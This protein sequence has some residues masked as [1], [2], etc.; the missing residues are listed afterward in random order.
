[1][2]LNG[3]IH[4]RLPNSETV[5]AD[6][7]ESLLTVL[8]RNGFF[9]T[10]VLCGGQGNCNACR[11]IVS[12]ADVQRVVKA[13]QFRISKY[14]QVEIFETGEKERFL[15][16]L[17][18]H[19][20]RLQPMYRIENFCSPHVHHSVRSLWSPMQQVLR[21][22]DS[23]VSG[24]EVP[25]LRKISG[26]KRMD[27]QYSL[28]M[29]DGQ[30]IDLFLPEKIPGRICGLAFDIGT[31]TI[32]G[33]LMDLLSGEI[34]ATS[35]VTNPQTKIALDLMNRISYLQKKSDSDSITPVQELSRLIR[36]GLANI[37]NILLSDRSVDAQHIYEI[38]I[39][40]NSLMQQL[41]LEI[42]SDGLAE[43]PYLPVTT[44][45]I[46]C[47]ASEIGFA[48]HPACRLYCFPGIGGFVGGDAMAML[49][50][51]LPQPLREIH[52]CIDIGTN[53]EIVL[54]TPEKIWGCSA[55]SGPAF[56]G[57]QIAYGMRATLGAV[58]HVRISEDVELA[59]IG[60]ESPRGLCGSGLVDAVA[61]LVRKK[62]IGKDG[63]MLDIEELAPSEYSELI[64]GRMVKIDGV[65]SFRLSKTDS[66]QRI[67]ITQ[68][69]VRQFQMAKAAIQTAILLLLRRAGIE[70]R[71]VN[72]ISLTGAF[73]NYIP[74]DRL[75]EL[76]ILQ[77]PKQCNISAVGNAAGAG[78][79]KVLY[80]AAERTRVEQMAEACEHVALAEMPEFNELFLANLMFP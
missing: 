59:V 29:R 64:L 4:V 76:G 34:L 61:E 5:A 67:Y 2:Y 54:A 38:S 69:D 57:G 66:L 79:C 10:E 23:I 25:I 62:L 51:C 8:Q 9:S 27:Q 71:D 44:Q 1:M 24:A 12:D 36:E 43:A 17:Q 75:I 28:L 70:W 74:P 65:M 33:Y 21:Q 80:S 32:A 39:A 22:S 11:V 55:A 56:E 42:P 60:D 48:V 72:N 58:E 49:L 63:R 37:A 35:A 47:L 31:T 52:L 26:Y 6:K 16:E 78:A 30:A 15:V 68:H 40:G 3:L 13:C 53:C 77:P 20:H 18:H 73:G 14:C 45:S 19:C 46:S 7:G 50:A 41:L